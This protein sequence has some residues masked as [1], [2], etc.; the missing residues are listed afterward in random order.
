MFQ[1]AETLEKKGD[2]VYTSASY[3]KPRGEIFPN[4][5]YRIGGPIGK[6]EHIVL[7]K[8][9]GYHGCYSHFATYKL[10]QKIKEVNPDI[11]HLH[12]IHGWYLNWKMLF[13]YLK[14]SGK[15]IVWTL[16]DCW[17]FT[18]HCP[19]FMAI[20]CEKWKNGCFKCPLY[21]LYPGCF[22]DDSKKQYTIKKRYFTGIPNMVIVTPSQWLANLANQSYLNK[23]R[24]VVI[25]N[26][27]DLGK[28][29][30]VLSEFRGKYKLNNKIILLGVA[31]DWGPRKGI[32]EFKRLAKELPKEFA[33]VLVGVSETVAKELPERIIPIACTQSQEELAE[34]YSAADLFINPTLEDNFP[35]VNLEALACGTPVITYQTGGSSESIT[36]ECGRVVPYKDYEALKK[37]IIEMKNAKKNME[38]ACQKRAQLYCREDAYQK[39][40]TLYEEII[41]NEKC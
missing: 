28:F 31:F 4:T 5:F 33:I 41:K 37:T 19:H 39:Y 35:T 3:T 2:T 8:V 14:T 34:I 16:H 10:I 29:K 22:I 24:T 40:V 23:Y 21:K 12:N 15:P 1:I 7:A 17:S 18:G 36:K 25:N 20:N 27:I 6:L 13:Q 32:N 38:A 30:F 9:T 11:I 26:G